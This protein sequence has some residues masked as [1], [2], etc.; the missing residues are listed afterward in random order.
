MGYSLTHV[1]VKSILFGSS[2]L[3]DVLRQLSVLAYVARRM[4]PIREIPIIMYLVSA[5]FD[6]LRNIDD[7]METP[8]WKSCRGYINRVRKNDSSLS[9]VLPIKIETES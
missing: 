9:H 4:G 8:M 2:L 7:Y 3:Q 5:M 6:T 1:P